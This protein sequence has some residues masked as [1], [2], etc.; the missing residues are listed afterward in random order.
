[1]SESKQIKIFFV[2]IAILFTFSSVYLLYI[3][4]RLCFLLTAILG[5]YLVKEFGQSLVKE[6]K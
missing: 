1:M 3:E 2:V 4:G 6:F 5:I